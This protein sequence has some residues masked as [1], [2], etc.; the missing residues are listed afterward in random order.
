MTLSYSF[1]F[2]LK[3]S[4][5]II[6]S[7]FVRILLFFVSIA[8]LIMILVFTVGC[9]NSHPPASQS[10]LV[11]IPQGIG[12]NE[13]ADLLHEQK[14]LKSPLYF[15]VLAKLK[16]QDRQLKAGRYQL[17]QEL[18]TSELLNILSSG[19]LYVQN[20]SIPEGATLWDIAGIL[21]REIHID[22]LHF[23]QLVLDSRVGKQWNL[24]GN[25]LEGYLFPE[26]YQFYWE[27]DPRKIVEI[28][29][30]TFQ[31]NIRNLMNLDSLPPPLILKIVTLASIIEKEA[32]LDEERQRISSVYYNRLKNRMR[33]QADPTVQY[34]LKKFHIPLSRKDLSIRNP[35]NTYLYQGLPPGPICNPGRT[36]LEAAINPEVTDFLYF[37]AKG[38]K[39][40]RH[41]FS[42]NLRDHI[43]AK[44]RAKRERLKIL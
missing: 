31:K 23:L 44:N 21:K 24:P 1:Y 29:I 43:N 14:I 32:V 34:A 33:L 18:S 3:K 17:H 10:T 2:F 13:I 39:S 9:S 20:V 35:Y 6:Q 16:K 27:M 19:N 8:T 15:K 38:D 25:S 30:T 40:G 22:S 26:T 11:T 28:M 5:A 4:E 36:S 7:L 42:L 12:L 41:Y 37:V